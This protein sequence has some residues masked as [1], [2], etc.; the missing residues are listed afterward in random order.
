M[1]LLVFNEGGDFDVSATAT[2]G[3]DLVITIS[4]GSKTIAYTTAG[5]ASTTL[6]AAAFVSDH[7][8]AISDTWQTFVSSAVAVITF[9]GISETSFA[10]TGGSL[11][12]PNV[13]TEFSVD[14]LQ[15][16]QILV[17]TAT[18]LTLN[19]NANVVPSASDV[20]T[21]T[22]VSSADR[23]KFKD[24]YNRAITSAISGGGVSTVDIGCKATKA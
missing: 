9:E 3:T 6:T 18:T 17:A 22:F 23:K 13:A 10:V 4:S 24:V 14:P 7:G 11:G 12:S 20:L 1:S 16:A 15:I 2:T 5:L 19:M 21:L 8:Q